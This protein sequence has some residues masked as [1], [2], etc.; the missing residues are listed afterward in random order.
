MTARHR[1][2]HIE[3]VK[4]AQGY[5]LYDL[6]AQNVYHLNQAA[7]KVIQRYMNGENTFDEN[8][9]PIINMLENMQFTKD[10]FD[11]APPE[12][13]PSLFYVWLEITEACNMNC[14]H[15][16]GE[17]GH[18]IEQSEQYLTCDEWKN[19]IDHIWD[20]G[21]RSIQLIGGEPLI[22]PYFPE[23]L[24]YVYNKGMKH[25]DVF[26]N[27]TLITEK[28]IN[29]FQE[30]HANIRVSLYGH[31]AKIHDAITNRP[32][33]F[34]KTIKNI[35]L[36]QTHNIPV[37]IAVI[38]MDLNEKYTNEIEAFIAQMG[39]HG[40]DTIRQTTSGQ[41][42]KHAVSRTDVLKPRY[43]YKALFNTSRES[44]YKNQ[45][46]NSCW[47]GKVAITSKGDIIPCIF[48]RECVLGNLRTNSY[49]KIKEAVLKAWSITKDQ[50]RE[51]CDCE[52]RYSCHD[53]RPLAKGLSGDLYGKYPR[54]C[55]NPANGIWEDIEQVTCELKKYNFSESQ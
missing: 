47:F 5:A 11:T 41:Q 34:E 14:V 39:S 23:L 26:T 46:W 4:G 44:F 45:K 20:A 8:E 15:C 30:T 28:L 50:V 17:W 25:I 43:Q 48:A 29:L 32:G 2:N 38:I 51:C 27:G 13:S 33:S 7:W 6:W 40:Y 18:P 55:Y 1:G 49:E 52:Y 54:C 21:C 31:T 35:S 36:L 37:T 16:Y 3:I 10:L 24:K 12:I 9:S 22:S 19:V 53:C 42:L